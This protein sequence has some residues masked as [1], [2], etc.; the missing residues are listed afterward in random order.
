[1]KRIICLALCALAA[2]L[3]CA[4]DNTKDSSTP[5]QAPPVETAAQQ[6]PDSVPPTENGGSV[7]LKK[8]I[9]AFDTKPTVTEQKKIYDDEKLSVSLKGIDYTAVSGPQLQLTIENKSDKEIVVQSPYS[10]VNGYMITPELNAKIAPSKSTDCSLTLPY[11][12]L[13]IA[14]ITSIKKIEFALR[15]VDSKTYNPI[16]TTELITV[17]TSAEQVKEAECDESGQVAYDDNDI[18]I[19]LKGVNTDR[20][21][22]DGTEVIVYMFNGTDQKIAI[23]AKDVVVNGYD[24][25]SAMNSTILPDKRAV[26]VVTIYKLDLKEHDIEEIDS[27]KVS[28]TIKDADNWET[29]DSTDLISVTLPEKSTEPAS[30]DQKTK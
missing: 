26:D 11:F 25:T 6:T 24:M 22:S 29:I 17:E 23:R 19:I 5:T 8:F 13:A 2:L 21:Y 16:A 27:I 14:G 12:K 9:N 1:M 28:F 20:A 30:E 4:C 10:I 3:A 7:N 18:K 15:S